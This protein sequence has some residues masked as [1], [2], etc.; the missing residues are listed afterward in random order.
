MLQDRIDSSLKKIDKKLLQYNLLPQ[1][2]WNSIEQVFIISTGRTGTQ[3]FARF[4][5]QFPD[6]VKSLHEPS[7]DFLS[8]AINYARGRVD[9]ETA[10]KEIE[11]NRRVFCCEFKR[12]RVRLYIESN[13]RFF[14]L[15]HPLRKAFPDSKIIYIVRDGRDYVR[16]GMSRRW[17][18]ENDK[19]PRMQATMFPDDPYASQWEHMSRF[20]KI[21]WRWQKKDG[22]INNDFQGLE[23]AIKVKFEDIFYD[24]DRKGLFEITRFIGLDDETAQHFLAEMGDKKVN[25]NARR[26]IPKWTDWDN[27]MKHD[28]DAIAGNHMK[29]H[30]DYEYMT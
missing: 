13:N 30:Y 11:R 10:A 19:L 24:P 7:P 16:S 1:Q 18:T 20:E 3:F 4:F 12:K 5:N 28:F 27:E 14:S 23:N 22:F 25:T 26:V 21:T 29:L 6:D 8:L 9:F 15:M 2:D 17:Y